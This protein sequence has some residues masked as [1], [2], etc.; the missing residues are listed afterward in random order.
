MR[1]LLALAVVSLLFSFYSEE[2]YKWLESVSIFFAVSFA[3][4][5]QAS[6]D[7]ARDQQFLKLTREI[8]NEKVTVIRG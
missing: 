6:C 1:F 3:A 4:F 8:R 2:P 5:I 7:Y